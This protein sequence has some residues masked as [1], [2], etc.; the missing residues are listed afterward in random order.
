MSS[1]VEVLDDDEE[2]SL[3]ELSPND[4]NSAS[5]GSSKVTANS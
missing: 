1:D 5:T 3:D 2:A 4:N